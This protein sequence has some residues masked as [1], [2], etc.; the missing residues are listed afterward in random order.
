MIFLKKNPKGGPFYVK[1]F[2]ISDFTQVS[3]SN[4]LGHEDSKHKIWAKLETKVSLCKGWWTLT[5]RN[6]GSN[7]LD[8]WNSGIKRCLNIKKIIWEQFF[9][10]GM[11]FQWFK[12]LQT[13]VGQK[14]PPA[15][16]V[17]SQPRWNR[18]MRSSQTVHCTA[19]LMKF[20][21]ICSF[22]L[23]YLLNTLVNYCLFK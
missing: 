8:C 4:F 5:D 15:D 14:D 21:S 7:F 20:I 6:K 23:R 12:W 18:V 1:N 10:V 22:C 2:F 13:R 3:S 11:T 19:N 16:N 17:I 9:D